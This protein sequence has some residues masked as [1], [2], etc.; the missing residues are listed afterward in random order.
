[1][2]RRTL[3]PLWSCLRN[4]LCTCGSHSSDTATSASTRPPSRRSS[5]LSW[6]TA[7][8]ISITVW[9]GCPHVRSWAAFSQGAYSR[10][11]PRKSHHCAGP[12]KEGKS[13]ESRSLEPRSVSTLLLLES[14]LGSLHETECRARVSRTYPHNFVHNPSSSLFLMFLAETTARMCQLSLANLVLMTFLVFSLLCIWITCS[15]LYGTQN[16][17]ENLLTTDFWAPP[18]DILIH[19]IYSGAPI[20]FF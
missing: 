4:S 7:S 2:R 19:W 5:V 20:L 8:D 6:V 16:H 15:K 9:H 14:G 1:M 10:M 11:I 17:L 18:S 13:S 3:S 12:W